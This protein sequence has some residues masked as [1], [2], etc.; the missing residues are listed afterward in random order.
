MDLVWG[1]KDYGLE[2]ILEKRKNN[3]KG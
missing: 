2:H 1:N 3:T